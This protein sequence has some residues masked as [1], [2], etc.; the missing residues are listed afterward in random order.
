MPL[1]LNVG[2]NRKAGEPNYGSRGASVN[3]EVELEADAIREP[4]QLHNKIRYL[5]QIAKEAVEEELNHHDRQSANGHGANGHDGNGASASAED[6]RPAQSGSNGQR[7][8]GSNGGNG[9]RVSQKQVDYIRQLA[10]QIKGLGVRRLD[11]LANKMFSKPIADL[12]SLNASGMIDTL[13]AIKAGEISLDI[14]LN[15]ATT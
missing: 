2:L 4:Q 14:A 6:A 7:T 9:H 3:F 13:K 10:G 11:T 8:G 5:F 12:T 1:R 15:G